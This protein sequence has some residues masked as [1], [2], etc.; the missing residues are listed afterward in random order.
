[1]GY[2]ENQKKLLDDFQKRVSMGEKKDFLALS[3]QWGNVSNRLE[4]RITELSKLAEQGKITPNK[5][6][7]LNEYKL[8]LAESKNQVKFFAEYSESVISKGQIKSALLGLN[9]GQ[10]VLGSLGVKVTKLNINA[11]NLMIGMSA[12]GSPLNELLMKSYPESVLRLTNTLIEGTALGRNPKVIAR[13]MKEDMNGNL[14]RALTICRTEELNAFR[15]SNRQQLEESGYVSKWEWS[16]ES[17]ACDICLEK[18]GKTFPISESMD[19]H[20]NCRCGM[21][22]VLDKK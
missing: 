20:P 8:F 5:L 10:E 9:L 1:M 22:P 21:L 11:T 3:S 7:Q 17:N 15:E 6:Y 14:S 12:D 2:K 13:M 18:D 4:K 19:T 16:A